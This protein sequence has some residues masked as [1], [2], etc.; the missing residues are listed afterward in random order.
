MP[1]LSFGDR[2]VFLEQ[3]S[4]AGWDVEDW[5]LVRGVGAKVDLHAEAEYSSRSSVLRLEIP[6]GQPYMVFQMSQPDGELVLRLRL[7][8]RDDLGSMINE[9][10]AAQDLLD[11]D[12]HP[13]LVKSLIPLS[14]RVV[15]ETAEGLFALS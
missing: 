10:I 11:D 15:L 14:K 13:Q 5:D 8:P 7:Y 2:R 3:L 9:I 6:T 1:G 4:Q 12:T